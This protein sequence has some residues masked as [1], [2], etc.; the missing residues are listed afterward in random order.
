MAES[1]TASWRDMPCLVPGWW[2]TQPSTCYR[3]G[4]GF[5][6]VH[7]CAGLSLGAKATLK[8]SRF[9][10]TQLSSFVKRDSKPYYVRPAFIRLFCAWRSGR[11]HYRFWGFITWCC[12]CSGTVAGSYRYDILT[13]TTTSFMMTSRE[14]ALSPY[15]SSEATG[16]ISSSHS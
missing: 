16:L 12:I 11:A 7:R 5:Q 14:P 15:I 4:L 13:L 9:A 8:P 3:I 6:V 2:N 1:S 10:T